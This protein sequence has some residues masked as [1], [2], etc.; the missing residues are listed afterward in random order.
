MARRGVGWCGFLLSRSGRRRSPLAFGLDVALGP[1]KLLTVSRSGA[2]PP[3][4][5][6]EF[7]IVGG[8]RRGAPGCWMVW[9]PT[10]SVQDAAEAR[11]R[12]AWAWRSG[13]RSFSQ[14]AAPPDPRR[15][16]KI[17][18]V[19]RRGEPG[20]MMVWW[21]TISVQDAAEAHGR[22]AWMWRLG[23][24][25]SSPSPGHRLRPRTPAGSSKS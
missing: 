23:L 21:P 25:S 16:F 17:V 18:G 22:L 12:L 14:G 11:R 9:W 6:R 10:I 2:A 1:E 3:D 15:E 20:C 13:L 5:R 19:V 7:K 8:V 24:R 4:R